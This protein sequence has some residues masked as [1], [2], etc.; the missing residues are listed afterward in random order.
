MARKE[1][2]ERLSCVVIAEDSGQRSVEVSD[3]KHPNSLLPGNHGQ[4]TGTEYL[5]TLCQLTK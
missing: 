5:Q 1:N 4:D 2:G 3:G